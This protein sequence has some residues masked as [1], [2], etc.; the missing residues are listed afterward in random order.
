MNNKKLSINRYDIVINTVKSDDNYTASVEIIFNI[1]EQTKEIELDSK[2]LKI[3]KCDFYSESHEN[4]PSLNFKSKNN[5]LVIN[6]SSKFEKE[7]NVK[8]RIEFEGKIADDLKGI[9]ASKYLSNSGKEEKL[10]STQFEPTD[11]R[12]AFPC[13]DEPNYKAK[14]NLTLIIHSNLTAISNMPIEKTKNL[15]EKET[16]IK[17]QETPI[18]S[19]Y[20]LFFAIGKIKSKQLKTNNNILI[21]VWATNEQEKFS[22][23]ALETSEKLL[24]YFESYF[25]TK[26]PLPKLDHIAIPDFAAGAMENW[27]CISYRETALLVDPEKSSIQTK[28]LVA[29]IIAHEMAHMW[30]GDLVTMDWWNDLWLNESFASWMGDKAISNLYPEWDVW[31]KFLLDDTNRAFELDALDSSH[32]IEQEVK[33]PDEI[34][35]LFDAISYSKG[36]SLIR[37]L[38]NYIGEEKFKKGIQQYIVKHQYKNTIT[39]D[40]WNAL[41]KSSNKDIK[42][43]MEQW[44]TKSGFPLILV[45]EENDKIKISQEKFSYNPENNDQSEWIVPIKYNSLINNTKSKQT[46]LLETKEDFIQNKNITIMNTDSSGFYKTS[47][48]NELFTKISNLL[49]DNINN[50]SNEERLGLI[51]DYYTLLKSSKIDPG[52]YLDLIKTLNKENNPYIWKYICGSLKSIDSKL[53]NTDLYSKYY[54]F[55]SEIFNNISIDLEWNLDK[56]PSETDQIM[57]ATLID[58][59]CY[60]GIEDLKNKS[61]Q[62]FKEISF[63]SNDEIHPNLKRPLLFSVAYNGESNDFDKIWEL[64]LNSNSQEEKSLYLG[65]LTQFKNID[66]IKFLLNQVT[67]KNIRKHDIASVLIG[68]ANNN[69]ALPTAWEYLKQNWSKILN[70]SGDGFQLNYIVSLPSYF[71]SKDKYEEVENYYS[72]NPVDAASMSMNQ[73]LEK[74]QNNIFWIDFNLKK[75]KNY[76]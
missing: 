71:Q 75:F 69:L 52:K 53:Y 36:A 57:I 72:E 58:S 63:N 28:Q 49:T 6:S 34:G 59:A 30:F 8:L 44:T 46:H 25:G 15:N 55:A 64:Y 16:Q 18:M 61:S 68:V 38:E 27:G 70:I 12:N 62:I 24:D 13:I 66:K 56:T 17:F 47:Y 51:S 1:D 14:F 19:T 48:S 7:E 39:N 54:S 40:L 20:L 67:T 3:I 4:Q 74:I 35:Q 26:Y 60:F 41:S 50:F 33:N 73:T 9:Y 43:L 11:A 42:T 45:S 29:A 31:T 76:L 2:E 32:P 23:F 5:K 65:S 37:M 10:I 21:R 22:D